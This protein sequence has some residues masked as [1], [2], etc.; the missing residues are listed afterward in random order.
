MDSTYGGT[1]RITP[2]TR[3]RVSQTGLAATQTAF[4][5]ALY[6]VAEAALNLPT[7]GLPADLLDYLAARV[8]A[9][10]GEARRH[11]AT[12]LD[13]TD[14]RFATFLDGAARESGRTFVVALGL[15][16]DLIAPVDYPT[17]TRYW[18][19]CRNAYGWRP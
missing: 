19:A 2:S 14:G 4:S 12:L 3:G 17:L 18:I 15:P 11:A 10:S 5:E 16:V 7:N 8:E 6:R 13:D 1:G 9:S